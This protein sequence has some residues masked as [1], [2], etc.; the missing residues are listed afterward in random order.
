MSDKQFCIAILKLGTRKG[1]PCSATAKQIVNGEPRCGRHNKEKID[2]SQSGSISQSF[3]K[4]DESLLEKSISYD[5]FSIKSELH[6]SI[7]FHDPQFNNQVVKILKED[8]VV[9]I[10]D[11][12]TIDQSD[13]LMEQIT[14]CF[15]KLGT[16]IIANDPDTWSKDKLPPQTRSGLYQC[17]MAN[18]QPVWDLR[19]NKNV[20]KIF[21]IIYSS[22]RKKEIKDFICSGDGINIRPKQSSYRKDNKDWAHLDQTEGCIEKCVQ[23]QVVLTNTTAGFRCS[24][25]SHLIFNKLKEKYVKSDSN[26]YKFPKDQYDVI[27]EMVEEIGGEWQIP[28]LTKKGSMI[29]WFSS[30]IHSARTQETNLPI[31]NND[32]YRDW[33]GVVYICYRPREE[34]TDQEIRKRSSA[35]VDNRVTNHW[36]TNIFQKR[37]G[38]HFLYINIDN[39]IKNLVDNPKNL[40]DIIGYPALSDEQK[41]IAGIL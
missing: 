1:E 22:L 34:L 7:S 33:R 37:V 38:N 25:K 26:W 35:F 12:L 27:K 24:P 8:G 32:K 40:Y 21:E 19:S 15:Q 23:G 20:K 16:G 3:S 10:D 41:R 5:K 39:K 31:N 36:S 29:L 11:V 30:L 13:T 9:V 17:L 18:I 14:N 28:I 4:T 2:I 6:K